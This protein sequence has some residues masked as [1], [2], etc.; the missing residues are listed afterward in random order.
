AAFPT[1]RIRRRTAG[2]SEFDL[3]DLYL[4]LLDGALPPNPVPDNGCCYAF[5]V[6]GSAVFLG[7][8]CILTSSWVE[9]D[10]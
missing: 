2:V 5:S 1:A 10:P 4:L 8:F 3:G 6:L 9:V 7:W